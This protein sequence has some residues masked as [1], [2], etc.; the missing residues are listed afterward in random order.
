MTFF[1][2]SSIFFQGETLKQIYLSIITV[3]ITLN[4]A[5][6]LYAGGD[7]GW[8]IAPVAAPYY[9]PDTKWAVGAYIVPF[10]K[11]PADSAFTKTDE[12]TF[13]IAYTELKQI[14]FGFLPEAFFADGKF[15]LSGKIEA[16]RYP[17][18][19][20][21]LGPDTRDSAEEQY[22]QVGWWGDI[23]V[24]IRIGGVLY[25]GPLYHYRNNTEKD[26]ESGGIIDS[27]SIPGINH[28]IESG[29]GFAF[30]VDTRNSIFFPTQGFCLTGKSSFQHKAFGSDYNFG[31][32]EY[33]IRYFFG[34]SGDHVMAFQFRFKMAHGEVPLETLSGIGGDDLMRGY[35][36]NRYLDKS[37]L[38]AQAEYRFPLVWRF[39]GTIF[40]G[41]GE[42]QP[43]L[44]R[45]NPSDL[46]PAA[47][48]GLRLIIDR[49][50]H[51]TARVDFGWND[52][53][54]MS[55]Y[56]LVKEAF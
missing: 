13:Y 43:S 12:Y 22:T 19:F 17:T 2:I 30:Q 37:S 31:R 47:G 39:A 46:H 34:I 55:I 9:T 42:V 10:Y 5:A 4:S 32:H 40:A 7:S 51:I 26:Y 33:D 29:P 52:T 41:A 35:I 3:L 24:M 36:E 18:R 56:F 54:S 20:W 15:K 8:G 21:G 38:A 44:K 28:Y 11:P 27:G 6:Y 16:C 45:Y 14:A 50:E 53:G 1:S 23:A 25:G 49:N 48:A